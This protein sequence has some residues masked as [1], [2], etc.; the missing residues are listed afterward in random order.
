MSAIVMTKNMEKRKKLYL[1]TR[2]MTM[3]M[4]KCPRTLTQE[5]EVVWGKY[6]D[7]HH[8]VFQS[9]LYSSLLLKSSSAL[10]LSFRSFSVDGSSSF[11][12]TPIFLSLCNA[13]VTHTQVFSSLTSKEM[14]GMVLWHCKR[15]TQLIEGK[16]KVYTISTVRKKLM[17]VCL[18]MCAVCVQS[19]LNLT[20]DNKL[21]RSFNRYLS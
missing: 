9:L 5:F 10:L 7:P 4:W 1:W 2:M 17:C 6:P 15:S 18:V 14:N 20:Y 12:S 16:K 13:V 21:I 3:K 19:V 8:H 11:L